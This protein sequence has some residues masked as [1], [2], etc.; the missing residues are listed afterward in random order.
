[1]IYINDS[2]SNVYLNL[3]FDV[4]EN[5]E[6]ITAR[7]RPTAEL[8]GVNVLLFDPAEVHVLRT[9]RK[10]SLK[11]AATEAMHLIGGISSLEQLNLTSTTPR[12]TEFADHGRLQGAYGPRARLQLLM[13]ERLLREDPGTR[14][15]GITIWK[16]TE[17]AI[18]SHDVP[19]TTHLHFY[20]RDGK[21]ELDVTM[22]S[23]DIM[24]GFP[25]D[26]MVFSCLQR[27][28]AASL[29][30]EPGIYR[31][32]AGSM[33]AYV[34]DLPRLREIAETGP[35]EP[36][37]VTQIPLPALAFAQETEAPAWPKRFANHASSARAVCLR[38]SDDVETGEIGW[39]FKHVPCLGS[40][41]DACPL[42]HYVVR[43]DEG[44][45]DCPVLKSPRKAVPP[46]DLQPY[47]GRYVATHEGQ[48]IADAADVTGIIATLREKGLIAQEVF[49]VPLHVHVNV[50]T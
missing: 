22:R 28:M 10:P 8:R 33:H 39:L 50:F 37:E 16:G 47:V 34:D 30:V 27:A 7:G 35:V 49:R 12:F 4:L 2:G 31:H 13:A 25:I 24:L 26:I 46:G 18:G 11:I 6:E 48:I 38:D 36:P 40:G 43:K 1:M 41:W 44:C 19:C 42:C 21:L 32:Y 45:P 20:L 3:V 15:A 29:G 17:T 14:Q 23:N 9:I 5:G